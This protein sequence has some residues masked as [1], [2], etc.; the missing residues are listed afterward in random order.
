MFLISVTETH[1]NT[2][3]LIVSTQFHCKTRRKKNVVGQIFES[4][5]PAGTNK[6]ITIWSDKEKSFWQRTLNNYVLQRRTVEHLFEYSV[7]RHADLLLEILSVSNR[8]CNWLNIRREEMINQ[9]C[10]RP[11]LACEEITSGILLVLGK[12]EW[13]LASVC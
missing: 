7:W 3:N 11:N 9:L 2:W 1:Q 13:N 5:F 6:E 12:S 10:L 8:D 4:M